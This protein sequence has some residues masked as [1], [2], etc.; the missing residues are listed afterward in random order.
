MPEANNSITAWLLQAADEIQFCIGVHQ[1]AEYIKSPSLHAI[2]MAPNYC[3][4]IIL[5]RDLM[6]PVIDIRLLAGIPYS[7]DAKRNR[8]VMITAYQTK[9]D[10]PIE[11]VAF[12]LETVP[13]KIQV[14]DD[15]ACKLPPSYP[16]TLKPY[17]VSLFKH[18]NTL[19]SVFDIAQLSLGN[20]SIVV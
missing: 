3:K 8:I 6:I 11:H 10:K 17:V 9:D 5:W 12:K 18:N 4:N 13:Q 2:P 20:A 19:T 16:D 7:T 14:H 1:A 15:S